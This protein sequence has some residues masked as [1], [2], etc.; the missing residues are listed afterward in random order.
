MSAVARFVTC[1]R[2]GRTDG[3]R[4]RAT[5]GFSYVEVLVATAI[6][7]VALSPALDA[8]WTGVMA[9]SL[10]GAQVADSYHVFGRFED[11]LAEPFASLEAAALAA[12]DEGT[13]SS[14]S[15]AAGASR[16]RL[17]FLSPYDGD[18][19]DADGDPWS[20]TDGDLLWVRVELDASNVALETLVIR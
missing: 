1:P 16:R 19:A 9:S 2:T 6:V 13:P 7:A 15:D 11:V 14:Y 4:R 10:A 3:H 12:G 18:D 17:V 5:A 20:G 8:L